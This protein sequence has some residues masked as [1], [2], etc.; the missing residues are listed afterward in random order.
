VDAA[1]DARA[2]VGALMSIKVRVAGWLP[3]KRQ[4]IRF[5]KT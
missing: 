5:D 3:L 2:A 1:K 4:V